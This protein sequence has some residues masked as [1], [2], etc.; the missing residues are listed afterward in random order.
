LKSCFQGLSIKQHHSLPLLLTA[1]Y[2]E[3]VGMLDIGPKLPIPLFP[4]QARRVAPVTTSAKSA[5]KIGTI[6]VLSPTALKLSRELTAIQADPDKEPQARLEAT[7]KL[8]ELALK[9]FT[10]E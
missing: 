6:V 2:L 3:G 8:R 1:I 4:D 9:V 10:G 5:I 7:E